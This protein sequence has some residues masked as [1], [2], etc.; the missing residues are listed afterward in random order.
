MRLL[1]LARS[2][3]K[4]EL[5]HFEKRSIYLEYRRLLYRSS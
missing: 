5:E 2:L 4:H 3:Q 1:I